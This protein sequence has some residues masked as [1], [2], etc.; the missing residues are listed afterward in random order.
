MSRLKWKWR[1]KKLENHLEV[2]GIDHGWSMMKTAT[3][4]FTSGVGEITSEPA[5]YENVIEYEGRYYRIGGER[6]TVKPTKVTDEKY[7]ILTLAAIAKELEQRGL[8]SANVYL[9]V[10]LPLTRFGAEKKEFM[11][12]LQ[13]KREVEF[14]YEQRTYRVRIEKVSVFPQCYSAVADKISSYNKK[15]LIV[16]VG[17]WTI[18]MMP[19]LEKSPDESKC[20]TTPQGLIT[21]MRSINEQCV[22]LLNGEL[23]ESEIQQVMRFGRSE[24]DDA[25][26]SIIRKEL[27]SFTREVYHRIGEHGYNLKTTPIVF[28]GGGATVMRLFGNLQQ[29]NITYIEDIKANAKGY[30]QLARL[31]LRVKRKIG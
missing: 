2:I 29:Q 10:G 27:E 15:V 22:R 26:V 18:D 11:E 13:R 7:Y 21:C 25:Y 9:A 31:A 19:I 14:K 1:N 5:I 20:V 17:S 6:L 3:Q 12:Y 24:L 23:D 8:Q 16:D 30:E 28:V 4:V